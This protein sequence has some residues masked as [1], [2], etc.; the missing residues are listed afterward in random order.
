MYCRPSP[1]ETL[2]VSLPSRAS[3]HF[4]ST[5]AVLTIV[6][7]PASHA[8]AQDGPICNSQNEPPVPTCSSSNRDD[9]RFA[10][11]EVPWLNPAN[12]ILPYRCGGMA[13]EVGGAQLDGG[14]IDVSVHDECRWELT[15]DLMSQHFSDPEGHGL[16]CRAVLISSTE[17]RGLSPRDAWIECEDE[18]RSSTPWGESCYAVILPQDNTPPVLSVKEETEILKMSSSL[19]S[20]TL[21]VIDFCGLSGQDNCTA[22]YRFDSVWRNVR[23]T[24]VEVTPDTEESITINDFSGTKRYTSD[25]I[26][27]AG[28]HFWV[29]L[30]PAKVE[31]RRYTIAFEVA[32]LSGN[33]S[34]I[35]CFVNL[36]NESV[37][38]ECNGVDDNCDGRVDENSREEIC[39]GLDDNCDGEVDNVIPTG[40][41]M[42]CDT[43]MDGVCAA[44]KF[45][46]TQG[47]LS[48]EP[49]K[50]ISEEV[51]DG[52]DNDCDGTIDEGVIVDENDHEITW[53]CMRADSFSMGSTDWDRTQEIHEVEVSRFEIM[54]SEVTVA[55]YKTWCRNA[56]D[57]SSGCG[58]ANT[59]TDCG[60]EREN[61]HPMDCISAE[62]ADRFCGWAADPNNPSE[63][64][65]VGSL[66]SEA[67]WEYAARG[68]GGSVT[69]KKYPWG[70]DDPTH[71]NV[72][73]Y[74]RDDFGTKEVCS[75][76]SENPESDLCDMAGNI[77]EWVEDCWHENYNCVSDTNNCPPV[78]GTAWLEKDEC[79]LHVVRGGAYTDNDNDVFRTTYRDQNEENRSNTIGFRCVRRPR[80][81]STSTS[82]TMGPPPTR[83]HV[84][85]SQRCYRETL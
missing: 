19:G 39:N 25:G 45:Q 65:L 52:K 13:C 27:L 82:T 20:T 59:R 64:L 21:D 23:V 55:Q 14:C 22:S 38:E 41:D 7:C 50:V 36:C 4:I 83:Q 46:C 2:G 8:T 18:C 77:A 9:C 79:T 56:P 24:D 37:D 57:M 40:C 44:G 73:M 10:P 16:S 34:E 33:K 30:N 61:D 47:R 71:E 69:E 72:V 12:D 75:I 11:G 81:P 48:C 68:S 62:D 84:D 76:V 67:E 85:G 51:C 63:S 29:N 78:D 70:D 3:I 66:P 49:D 17:G 53:V 74:N 26:D 43:G 60:N 15:S 5:L 54:K 28:S 32:D 80:E 35:D 6:L 42:I 58:Y 1:I 31:P